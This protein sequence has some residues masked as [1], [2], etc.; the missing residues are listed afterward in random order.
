MAN[1]IHLETG[2]PIAVTMTSLNGLIT[3]TT[4]GGAQSAK[5]DLTASRAETMLLRAAIAYTTAI[6]AGGYV[7]FYVGFS[8]ISTAASGNPAN[9]SGADAA[10]TGYLTND[11]AV[12]V[13]QLQFVG[14]LAGS[15]LVST[16]VPQVKDVG[17]F[18]PLDR[19]VM[20]VAVNAASQPLTTL[21]TL[22]S[23]QIIPLMDEVQ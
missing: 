4:S 2:T 9:L 20:V 14:I 6:T 21:T 11:L 8:S 23:V 17:V 12:S 10:Y 18:T 1:E 3:S 13:S 22:Q 5:T 16:T 19:Y 15:L 7:A